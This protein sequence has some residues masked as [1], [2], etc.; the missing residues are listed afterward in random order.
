MTHPNAV[1]RFQP[2]RANAWHW[3]AI[4]CSM[5]AIHT[6]A[7]IWAVCIARTDP[8][9][10]VVK[11]AYQ[12]GLRLD[13]HKAEAAASA[14]LGWRVSVDVGEIIGPDG[15][16][17][18]ALHAVDRDGTPLTGTT[19]TLTFF[20]DALGDAPRVLTLVADEYGVMAGTTDLLRGG[21]WSFDI[22]LD[23]GGQHFIQAI[24]SRYINEARRP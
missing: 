2:A 12:E 3:P 24:N 22:R 6:L 23:R 20:H 14:A 1:L 18:I 16:R 11:N 8:S 5:L 4:V 17:T 10:R 15:R 9:F 19:A 13:Q 7:M 21:F